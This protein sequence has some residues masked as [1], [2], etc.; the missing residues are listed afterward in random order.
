MMMWFE[1]LTILALL[2]LNGI[3]AMAEM[4]IVS[5]RKTRLMEL[6]GEGHRGARAAL[7][8]QAAPGEFLSTIQI[9]IT[10]VGVLAGAFGGAT[11]ARHLEVVLEKI[12]AVSVY[13][14][15]ISVAVVVVTITFVSLVMGEL[16]PKQLALRNA[17]MIAVRMAGFMRVLSQVLYPFAKFLN[18]STNLILRVIAPGGESRPVITEDEIRLMIDQATEAGVVKKTEQGMIKGVMN[19]GDLEAYDLMTPRHE[20]VWLDAT[21]PP[22]KNWEKILASGHTYFPVVDGD[23]A[24]I[25]GLVSVKALLKQRIDGKSLTLRDVLAP[26]LYVAEKVPAIRVLEKFKANN[27]HLALVVD[28]HGGIEGLISI[29][30]VLKAVVGDI[31]ASGGVEEDPNV[32]ERADGSWL[33]DGST[34]LGEL[35][36]LLKVRKLP[37]EEEGDYTTL[38]G[39]IMSRLGR[40]PKTADGFK[41][42][43]YKFEVVDM[44]RRRIDKVLII[45]MPKAAVKKPGG[46]E[47]AD[48]SAKHAPAT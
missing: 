42:R 5:S 22:E 31:T 44:D 13:A 34:P 41:W 10:L 19:L 48:K 15:E 24:N 47:D 12:P 32:V 37:R 35:K 16:V 38:A 25:L 28:E 18:A 23:A 30:D 8:I 9:G 33:V 2:A 4:A 6:S 40:V 7:K 3:F 11:V 26:P 46:G 27:T 43:N 45:K 20:V 17:E 29:N 14:G 21:D 36:K 39:F 1:I